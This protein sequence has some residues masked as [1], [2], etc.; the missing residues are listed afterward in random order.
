MARL[1]R[2]GHLTDADLTFHR[3]PGLI[4]TRIRMTGVNLSGSLLPDADFSGSDLSDSFTQDAAL[5]GLK[6]PDS[7][8]RRAFLQRVILE[9]ADLSGGNLTEINLLLCR[10]Q[11]ANLAGVDLTSAQILQSDLSGVRLHRADL[12]GAALR[13][14]QL[15]GAEFIDCDLRG[16]DFRKSNI[17]A[18][19]YDGSLTEGTIYY[20]RSPWG[21]GQALAENDW[22]G[23]MR[24]FDGE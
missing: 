10:L 15:D 2:H 14:C 5:I 7:Q 8:W 13:E 19:S 16:V 12:R 22:Y 17:H 3:G 24:N 9:G 1:A 21:D 6:A 11:G 18:A 23:R 4:L 20:G